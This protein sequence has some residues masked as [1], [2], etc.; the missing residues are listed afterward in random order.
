MRD[1]IWAGIGRLP[2]ISAKRRSYFTAAGFVFPL[3]GGEKSFNTKYLKAQIEGN[4]S[5]LTSQFNA[6]IYQIL[7]ERNHI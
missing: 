5:Q 2:R 4:Q 1:D 7:S 3:L 6:D